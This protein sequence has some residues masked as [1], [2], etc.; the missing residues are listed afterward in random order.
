MQWLPA[1]L[2]IELTYDVSVTVLD[3]GHV[4]VRIDHIRD[5][6]RKAVTYSECNVLNE[7]VVGELKK[8]E[9]RPCS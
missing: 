7:N 8:A 3:E 6:G 4:R 9:S 1:L 5:W 2:E